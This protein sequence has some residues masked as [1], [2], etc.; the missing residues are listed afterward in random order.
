MTA[1]A[2]LTD[3]REELN[4]KTKALGEIFAAAKTDSGYDFRKVNEHGLEGDQKAR[5]E[6]VQSLMAEVNDLGA[7]AEEFQLLEK[8]EQHVKFLE[9]ELDGRSRS[10]SQALHPAMGGGAPMKSIGEMFAG[11]DQLK[12]YAVGSGSDSQAL[13]LDL[14]KDIGGGNMFD[15]VKTLMTTS[16]GWA[17]EAIRTGRMVESA[18]RPVQ[19]IDLIP[20]ETTNQSSVVYMVESTF[21]NNAAE[22]AEGGTYGEAALA[23][24]ETT[25]PVRK[26]GVWLPVTDEQLEDVAQLQSYINNRLG[27]MVRQRLDGQLLVGDGIAPNLEGVNTRSG[28]QT[29]AKGGDTTLDAIYKARTKVRVTG[30]AVPNALFIHP[31]DLQDIALTRTADG[32]YILGNPDGEGIISRI[33]GLRTVETDA[34]TE[35]TGLVGDTTMTGL[36]IKRNLTLQIS[37]SHSTFFVE[38]KQAIRADLRAALQVYRP[39]AFC[40]VTGI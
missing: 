26:V 10:N 12:G 38:G 36:A 5:V 35:N 9:A 21:T 14:A 23:L 7:K 25:S 1:T 6:R 33:W 13:E 3:V 31:N 2:E 27:F 28:V 40:K 24:T 18:Q 11:S 22:V 29:Q 19:V 39:A 20:G 30:R 15:G 37:N 34:Q 17:P 4:A 8:A 16:A 32:I